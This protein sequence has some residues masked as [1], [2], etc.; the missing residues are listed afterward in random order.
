MTSVFFH[1]CCSCDIGAHWCGEFCSVA[2]QL[3]L[4]EKLLVEINKIKACGK[5]SHLWIMVFSVVSVL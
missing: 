1:F 2:T 4:D 5:Q 3:A